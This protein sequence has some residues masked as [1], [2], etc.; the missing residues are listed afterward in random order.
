MAMQVVSDQQRTRK[1]RRPMHPFTLR[2]RPFVIQPVAFL[3]VLPGE[4]LKNVSLMSRVVSDPV[5]DKMSGCHC[6]YYGFYIKIRDLDGR[7]DFEQMLIDPNKDMAAYQ[8][9]TANPEFYFS[10]NSTPMIPWAE[11]CYRRI[12]TE[13]FRGD[14]EDYSQAVD[15]V[16]GLSIAAVNQVPGWLDSFNYAAQ[17]DDVDVEIS[18]AGDDAFTVREMQAAELQ[19]QIAKLQGLT[20]KSFEDYLRDSGV[21]GAAAVE[22]HVPELLFTDREWTYPTNSV[23]PTDGSVAS[24]WIWSRSIRRQE[25]KFFVE[26]GFVM[27]LTIVRPKVQY[28]NLDGSPYGLM[29][30]M[31]SW[32][33]PDLRNDPQAARIGLTASQ[34]PAA[35][36]A[37]IDYDFSIDDLLMYGDQWRNYTLDTATN[38]VALPYYPNVIIQNLRYPST[39]DI[40]AL[41]VDS[42][43]ANGLRFI[44]Q[45]GILNV[46]IQS[47]VRDSLKGMPVVAPA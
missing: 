15:T 12:V 42:A 2:H 16:S 7:D 40:N 18:T 28:A 6:E 45:D 9:T 36:A 47:Y 31:L 23:E 46:A 26:P 32:L 10:P 4:T 44:R 11:L 14:E 35:S 21:K 41:F 34:G 13:H 19:Y 43:D 29:Q 17:N 38:S 8:S 20:Q 33:T 39:A 22:P 30:D 3:P 24:A 5:A 25:A 1:Q 27:V 37:D